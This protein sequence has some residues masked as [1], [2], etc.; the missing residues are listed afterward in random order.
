[1][2]IHIQAQALHLVII[3]CTVTGNILC[4]HVE[5][6]VVLQLSCNSYILHFTAR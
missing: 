6:L 2:A 3:K 1:M 5:W 4:C